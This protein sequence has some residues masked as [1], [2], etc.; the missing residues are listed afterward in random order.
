MS[1]ERKANREGL[2]LV[3]LLINHTHVLLYTVDA[4]AAHWAMVLLLVPWIPR[5]LAKSLRALLTDAFVAARQQC[6]SL[7]LVHADVALAQL[8][9]YRCVACYTASTAS[10]GTQGNVCDFLRAALLNL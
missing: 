7:L 3:K 9:I 2:L 8:K 4:R 6:M 5:L 10:D 1:L